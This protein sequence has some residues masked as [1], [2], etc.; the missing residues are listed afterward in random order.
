MFF[1]SQISDGVYAIMQLSG[2]STR[3]PTMAL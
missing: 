2:K 3:T 1:C